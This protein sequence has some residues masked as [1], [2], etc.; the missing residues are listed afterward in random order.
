MTK[1]LATVAFLFAALSLGGCFPVTP[2]PPDARH[3]SEPTLDWPG[4]WEA[5]ELMG[6]ALEPGPSS[7]WIRFDP[8]SRRAHGFGGCNH[9]SGSFE[10]A[11]GN[12][13]RFS[14]LAAT[15]MACPDSNVEQAFMEVLGTADSYHLGDSELVLHRA[16]M[17]P[18]ARFR[19]VTGTQ[20]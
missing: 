14:K 17:A 18:L 4:R 9:F 11:S 12:R 13:I 1:P 7:P 20:P 16:R 19:A 8:D 2:P 5:T 10:L 6:K 3:T 15:L